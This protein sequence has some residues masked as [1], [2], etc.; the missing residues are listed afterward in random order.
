MTGGT[1]GLHFETVNGNAY[2]YD[3]CSGLCFPCPKE[4]TE[5]IKTLQWS[6]GERLAQKK[7]LTYWEKFI[8]SRNQAYGAFVISN[9]S[10]FFNSKPDPNAIRTMVE[11]KGFFQLILCT[12]T[13]C[14][15]KCRY[16]IFS[17]EYPHAQTFQADNMSFE[18]AIKAIDYYIDK[19]LS[20]RKRDP[21]KSAIIS[22]YG[23]EPLLQF[24]LIK[25]IIEYIIARDIKN[26]RF[27]LTTNATLL[28]SEI[29]DFLVANNFL[30]SISIDGPK[31]EHDR[32]RVKEN[33]LGTFDIVFRNIKTFWGRYPNYEPLSF[34]VTYDLKTDLS[35]LRVFFDSHKEFRK[36]P[37]LFTPVSPYFTNYYDSSSVMDRNEFNSV[38]TQLKAMSGSPCGTDPVLRYFVKTPYLLHLFR[39][40][41]IPTNSPG[42]WGTGACL[43]GSKLCVFPD[44][45]IYPCEKVPGLPGIGSVYT[46]LNYEAIADLIASYNSSVTA[47]CPDCPI[48]RICGTCF[49]HFWSGKEFKMPASNFCDTQIDLKRQILTETYSL[50]ENHPEFFGEAM[51]NDWCD[52]DQLYSIHT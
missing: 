16:C 50:L 4:L 34:L 14:N 28:T 15:L 26:V 17:E 48:S 52:R 45:N 49:P 25:D 22:F 10:P 23:G 11:S 12:T 3:D 8:L 32:N 36:Y 20:I 47:H 29:I 9:R 7:E 51:Y 39:R 37:F 46:G 44:G 13:N 31:I 43:P 35:R 2:Y 21:A 5:T 18:V 38:Y 19:I 30:V 6:G 42:I 24:S 1:R 33:G 40:L 41:I 27:N